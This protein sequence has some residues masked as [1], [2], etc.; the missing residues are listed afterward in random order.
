MPKRSAT[1][2][3]YTANRRVVIAGTKL[4]APTQTAPSTSTSGGT[5][6]AATTTYY[7]V[8]TV[9]NANGESVKSNE[10][11]VLTGAGATN[12]NTVNWGAVAGATGYRVYRGLAS[13]VYTGY[14]QVGAVVTKV[15]TGAA[16]DGVTQPP[17]VDSTGDV[18]VLPGTT[19][20]NA[21]LKGYRKLDALISRRMIYPSAEIYPKVKSSA[22]VRLKKPKPTHYNAKER[23]NL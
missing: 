15:D 8:V 10:Q 1:G 17:T 5:G 11:S 18:V 13:G 20:S 16:L 22:T 23:T 4:G 21:I 3:T 12:S 14:Y 19:I 9:L 2:L 7:Y 6:L